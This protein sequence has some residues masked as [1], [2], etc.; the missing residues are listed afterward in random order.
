MK[1][2]TALGISIGVLA[3]VFTWIAATVQSIGGLASPLVVWVGF[4]A[5]ACHYAAGGKVE[6][7]RKALAGNISGLVWGWLIVLAA[8]ALGGSTVALAAAVAVAAFGMCV[9]ANWSVLAFIPGAF[10]GAAA[11][12]G[13]GTTVTTTLISLVAGALFGYASEVLGGVL[14]KARAKRVPETV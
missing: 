11:F 14:M 9:Q 1:L 4:A 13:N 3:G 12:F 10:V 8:T 5:W 7:L 2:L 6:G